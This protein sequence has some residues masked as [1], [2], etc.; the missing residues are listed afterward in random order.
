MGAVQKL[1]DFIDQAEP[2]WSSEDFEELAA[3]AREI[4]SRRTGVY[5][6][7]DEE[8]TAIEQGLAQAERGAAPRTRCCS[9]IM[10]C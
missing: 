5:V 10:A 1:R 3:Y 6:L 9:P 2:N 4:E 8:R 7:S